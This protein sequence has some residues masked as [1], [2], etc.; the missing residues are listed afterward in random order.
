M[1]WE[2]ILSNDATDKSLIYKY[3]NNSYNSTAKKI[4]NPIEK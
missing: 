1:E 2:K 4:N 3:M